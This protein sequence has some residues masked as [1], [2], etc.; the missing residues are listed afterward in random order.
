MIKYIDLRT[1]FTHENKMQ[2]IQVTL[3]TKIV[4]FSSEILETIFSRLKYS[5]DVGVREF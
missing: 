1:R 2:A 4:F 3:I 5:F